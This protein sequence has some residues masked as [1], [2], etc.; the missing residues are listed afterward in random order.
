MQNF[1]LSSFSRNV[2]WAGFSN[3]EE[4]EAV[5]KGWNMK[6]EGS[7]KQLTDKGKVCRDFLWYFN[8]IGDFPFQKQT[9][10]VYFPK[11]MKLL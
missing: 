7:M 4:E 6:S 3:E 10:S 9:S 5:V 11:F 2:V 8:G 1:H